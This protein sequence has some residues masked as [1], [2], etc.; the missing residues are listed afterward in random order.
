M[1]NQPR[2]LTNQESAFAAE[3]HHLLHSFLQEN[4][5]SEEEYYDVAVFGYL[6]AVRRYLHTDN[7]DFCQLAYTLML[8]AC[9]AYDEAQTVSFAEL[10]SI[11][12]TLADVRDT[13]EE[14]IRAV[15]LE[16]TLASYDAA[17]K[18]VV[19]L[20][21]MN[22]PKPDIAAMLGV[23]M[24]ALCERITGIQHKTAAVLMAA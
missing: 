17:E 16:Q 21:L 5:L 22:Y 10:S 20:L 12:D 8:S 7:G 23:D 9:N 14:A 11:E 18:Q 6:D 3:H 15:A 2:P 4:N 1:T 13:A 24:D 19:E